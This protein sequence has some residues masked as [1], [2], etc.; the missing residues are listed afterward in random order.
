MAEA[1]ID[2]IDTSLNAIVNGKHPGKTLADLEY[3]D[4]RFGRKVFYKFIGK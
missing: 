3:M 2:N 4:L 1:L